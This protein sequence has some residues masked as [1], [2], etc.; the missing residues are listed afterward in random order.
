MMT[1]GWRRYIW[2]E[3]QIKDTAFVFQPETGLRFEGTITKF[4]NRNKSAKAVVSLTCNNQNEFSQYE[5]DADENGHFKFDGIAFEDSTSVIIQAKRSKK[6][7]KNSGMNYYIELDKL[8]P[9]KEPAWLYSKSSVSEITNHN[10]P[11]PSR[12]LKELDSLYSAD[13][14]DILIKEVIVPGKKPDRI[15]EK[16]TLYREPSYSLNIGESNSQY[17]FM[18]VLQIIN[19]YFPGLEISGTNAYSRVRSETD[20]QKSG[21]NKYLY[22][23]DGI[24]SDKET[25]LSIP[26]SEIHFID[27]LRKGAKTT[28]FGAPGAM[29]VIAVYTL[30]AEDMLN[31]IKPRERK[32]IM[33]YTHPGFSKAREFYTPVYSSEKSKQKP[34]YR[35]TLYWNPTLKLDE[36]DKAKISFYT[37]D[38]PSVY[39]VVLEGLSSE[40]DIIHSE[41]SFTVY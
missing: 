31:N 9:P 26:L 29:G 1:Q 6:E 30:D 35:T 21:K 34:D 12:T 20:P 7:E 15:A 38:V 39:K 41:T 22:L 37:S 11:K 27:Y 3:P 4:G 10:Y 25:I 19:N 24:P 32:G 8:T 18:N 2:N 17:G 16:R 13:K 33:N 23:L 5:T 36:Q 40:G 28:I 14:G